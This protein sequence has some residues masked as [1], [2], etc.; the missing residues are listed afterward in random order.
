MDQDVLDD[1]AQRLVV[2]GPV[3]ED[4][5]RQSQIMFGIWPVKLSAERRPMP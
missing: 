3:V 1:G 4:G 5:Q 2:P